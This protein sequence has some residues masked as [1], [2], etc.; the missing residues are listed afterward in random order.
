MCL[1]PPLVIAALVLLSQFH[2]KVVSLCS[3][4]GGLSAVHLALLLC[5]IPE[6]SILPS[7]LKIIIVLTIL[8]LLIA[9]WWLAEPILPIP[10]SITFP[11]RRHRDVSMQL[12]RN[13]T[14]SLPTPNTQLPQPSKTEKK[15]NFRIV[16]ALVLLI[17]Y[18]LAFIV[19]LI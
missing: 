9:I 8:P 12:M 3:L 17:L 5:L 19:I 1:F 4:L 2:D 16:T 6:A 13:S 15:S 14:D 7:L 10:Q 11:N 18:I